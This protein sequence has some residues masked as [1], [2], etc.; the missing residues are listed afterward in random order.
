MLDQFVQYVK[1]L[2]PNIDP[3]I[4]DETKN[5]LR[6]FNKEGREY[7]FITT[8]NFSFLAQGDILDGIPFVRT[9]ADGSIMAHRG[10]GM[11]IS[12]TCSCD[13][14]DCIVIAPLI[15][16]ESYRSDTG[17]IKKNLN[18]KLMYL[19]EYDNYVIDFSLCNTVNKNMILSQIESR[20]ISKECTLN[21]LGFYLLI[22]KLTVCFLR[23]ENAE[24]QSQRNS[25]FLTSIG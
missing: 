13:H 14:D 18:Y 4:E 25:E 20:K 1:R 19:K 12:N 7:H 21:Q 15:N 3:Y 11:V 9:K 5:A 17:T 16:I 10:K 2:F 6:Q 24:V 23:P 8:A 22:A